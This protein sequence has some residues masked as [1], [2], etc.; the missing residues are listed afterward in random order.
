MHHLEAVHHEQCQT[1]GLRLP[2]FTTYLVLLQIWT[3]AA[4]LP[5]RRLGGYMEPPF[6]HLSVHPIRVIERFRDLAN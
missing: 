3:F 4:M 2:P 1:I 5:R 6:S